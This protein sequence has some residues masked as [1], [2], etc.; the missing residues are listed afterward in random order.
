MATS[1]AGILQ[2]HHRARTAIHEVGHAIMMIEAGHRFAELAML[3]NG[4]A[5]GIMRDAI[6]GSHAQDDVVRVCLG[7]IVAA[8]LARQLWDDHLFNSAW[9]DLGVVAD[10][11]R[12]CSSPE[13]TLNWNL[14][15][16]KTVLTRHWYALESIA[17]LLLSKGKIHYDVCV[18]CWNK[19]QPEAAAPFGR[20]GAKGWKP[21]IEKIEWRINNPRGMVDVMERFAAENPDSLVVP[22]H[23]VLDE[24][25][26]NVRTVDHDVGGRSDD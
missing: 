14:D 26:R 2:K 21:L 1:A 6:L 18:A 5:N 20:I 16:T 7:G 15:R 3:T 10:F 24:E 13:R 11:L 17:V 19:G 8:R 25:P 4:E 23:D 12:T 22:Q 9:D